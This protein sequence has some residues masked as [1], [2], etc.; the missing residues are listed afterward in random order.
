MYGHSYTWV[1][2][3]IYLEVAVEMGIVGLVLLL[4]ALISQLRAAS[5]C[6]KNLP[7]SAGVIVAYEAACYAI[8]VSAFF[9]GVLWEKWFW[10]AWILL[11]VAVRTAQTE[12]P[13]AA[14]ATGPK[15]TAWPWE[16]LPMGAAPRV[17]LR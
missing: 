15:S 8:M 4:T 12:Q 11:A 9:I 10:L 2:H 1:A 6:R 16:D 17:R 5:R 14:P 7:A 13:V 3:N